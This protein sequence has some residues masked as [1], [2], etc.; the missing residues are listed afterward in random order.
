MSVLAS[1]IHFSRAI[2]EAH[3]NAKARNLI[4]GS[5]PPARPGTGRK[6]SDADSGEELSATRHDGR[7]R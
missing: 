6:G 3:N 7:W 5:P 4:E 2:I 1:L